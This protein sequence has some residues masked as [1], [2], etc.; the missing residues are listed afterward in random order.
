MLARSIKFEH[1]TQHTHTHKHTHCSQG[2]PQPLVGGKFVREIIMLSRSD[3]D[4]AAGWGGK[5]T[6]STPKKGKVMFH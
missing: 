1:F 6:R 5:K 4:V 2:K 3:D